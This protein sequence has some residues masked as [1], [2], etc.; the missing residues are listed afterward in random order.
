MAVRNDAHAV[1]ELPMFRSLISSIVLTSLVLTAAP[2]MAQ[3][4]AAPSKAVAD[5]WAKEQRPT[6]AVKALLASYAAV[7]SLDLY[8]TKL[9]RD[10]GALEANPIMSGSFTH[11]AAMKALM[12]ATTTLAVTAIA[13]KNR[14]AAV[15]TMIAVDVATAAVVANNLHNAQQLR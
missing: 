13:K 9:A 12:G 6:V 10:R 3:E 1:K 4:L 8:T 11:G 5:A 7:E 14:K 2:V 15:F